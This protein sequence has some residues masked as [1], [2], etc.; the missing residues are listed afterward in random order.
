MHTPY[1]LSHGQ[2]QQRHQQGAPPAPV[3]SSGAWGWASRSLQVWLQTPCHSQGRDTHVNKSTHVYVHTCTGTHKH[4]LTHVL[5][6]PEPGAGRPA[7]CSRLPKPHHGPGGNTPKKAPMSPL[8]LDAG[9][10]LQ[11]MWKREEHCSADLK[12]V[13]AKCVDQGGHAR[14]HTP[15]N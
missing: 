4:A 2:A 5:I 10:C 8:T 13:T 1:S 6:C 7:A 14:T 11:P 9:Y 15:F 12:P 3:E